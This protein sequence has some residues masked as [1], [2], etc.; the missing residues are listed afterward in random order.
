M[1]TLQDRIVSRCDPGRLRRLAGQPNAGQ[2]TLV[3]RMVGGKVAM[4]YGQP[5]TTRREVR[6]IVTGRRFGG[7]SWST[8]PRAGARGR[9]HRRH[10]APT[11]SAPD[12]RRRRAAL[13]DGSRR[14]A[15]EL[16]PSPPPSR[17]GVPAVTAA[18]PRRPPRPPRTVTALANAAD[19]GLEG[20]IFPV[21]TLVRRG[22]ALPHRASR[23]AGA[24]GPVLY[25]PDDKRDPVRAGGPSRLIREQVLRRTRRRRCRTP[26]RSRSTSS[27]S[28]RTVCSMVRARVWAETE[29][30]KGCLVGAQAGWSR[31]RWRRPRQ[32]ERSTGRRV[33]LDLNVRV[34][35]GWRRDEAL[36]DRLGID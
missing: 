28:A 8:C 29:F 15:R 23:R 34:R 32:I 1:L 33:H 21:S 20:E 5:R 10:P 4:V 13:L 11:S 16:A 36:L 9:A 6:G 7:W 3:N 26:W 27:R 17:A 35:K 19:L 18:R 25:P 31:R 12:G 30:Q 14:S 2:S 22:R 24:R